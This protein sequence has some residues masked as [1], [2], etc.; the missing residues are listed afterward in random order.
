MEVGLDRHNRRTEDLEDGEVVDL[1][2]QLTPPPPARLP[3]LH[4]RAPVERSSSPESGDTSDS[5]ETSRRPLR[6]STRKRIQ[7]VLQTPGT[8]PQQNTSAMATRSSTRMSTGNSSR[9][10]SRQS[11]RNQAE[12]SRKRHRATTQARRSHCSESQF[13]LEVSILT[14]GT[15]VPHQQTCPICCKILT[16]NS[17]DVNN[18]VDRCLAAQ[19]PDQNS[20][21]TVEYEWA[22]ET[23]VRA[24]AMLEGGVRAAGLGFSTAAEVDDVDVDIDADD[25]TNYGPAQYTNRDLDFEE[26]SAAGTRRTSLGPQFE[27]NAPAIEAEPAGTPSDG[28]P[29]SP[30]PALSFNSGASQ[31][32]IDALKERIRQQDRLIQATPKCFV[33]LEPFVKPCTSINCWH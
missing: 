16:G 18:H 30:H 15:A 20:G 22:G 10:S 32:I 13:S 5:T 26:V 21:P 31:L 17:T 24:T 33:C 14:E 19:D 3:R 6:R 25:E 8:E 11:S 7:R 28:G 4:M 1:A 2:R 9:A 23:R 27:F 29:S 12:S